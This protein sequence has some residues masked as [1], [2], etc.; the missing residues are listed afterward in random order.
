MEGSTA[1]A[2]ERST[3]EQA[4]DAGTADGVA[5]AETPGSSSLLVESHQTQGTLQRSWFSLRMSGN[6]ILYTY[7]QSFEHQW[8]EVE[9]EGDGIQTWAK[10]LSAV[11]VYNIGINYKI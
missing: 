9:G 1:G 2:L 7:T 8:Y 6:Y 4:I 10:D 5:T 3:S 11:K